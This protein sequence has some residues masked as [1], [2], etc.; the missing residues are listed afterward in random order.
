MYILLSGVP[1]FYSVHGDNISDG[2]K[3][4]IKA[5]EYQFADEVWTSVSDEAKSTIRRML[6]VDPAQRITIDEVLG[7]AWLTES[8]SDRQIDVSSLDDAEHR[9]QT[10]VSQ[11]T[12]LLGWYYVGPFWCFRPNVSAR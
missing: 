4:K 10:Q 6:V 9:D 1:P 3:K 11:D 2:M 5:A 7:C 8:V 12:I